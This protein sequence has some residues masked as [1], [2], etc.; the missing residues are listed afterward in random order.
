MKYFLAVF[1][2][3]SSL[4]S[5]S[6]IQYPELNSEYTPPP[7]WD[8]GTK[9]VDYHEYTLAPTK[10]G[11]SIFLIFKLFDDSLSRD[12]YLYQQLFFKVLTAA[13]VDTKFAPTIPSIMDTTIG[14]IHFIGVEAVGDNNA[15]VQYI[16][17]NG[18]YILSMFY[19]ANSDDWEINRSEYYTHFQ[20]MNFINIQ[21]SGIAKRPS[22]SKF[23]DDGSQYFFDLLGRKAVHPVG[24]GRV[25]MPYTPGS[26]N[27]SVEK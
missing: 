12:K 20:N 4:Y 8:P 16:K 17:V 22:T 7:G 11:K 27:M 19:S 13:K 10:Q 1:L 15:W 23:L 5:Q 2:F 18:L 6:K 24:K 26:I 21:L 9:L 25:I 3:A 14:S